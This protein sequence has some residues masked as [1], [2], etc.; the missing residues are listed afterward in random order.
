MPST[1][2]DPSLTN[3]ANIVSNGSSPSSDVWQYPDTPAQSILNFQ[4]VPSQPVP[5]G[6]STGTGLIS[7]DLL[8]PDR[9]KNFSP[10]VFDLSPDSALIHFMQALLGDSGVGQL[11]KRQVITRLQEGITGSQ[12]YDLD[13][14]YG[15]LFNTVRG[16]TSSLPLNP[17]TGVPVNPY[18]D[19]ASPDGWD[20]IDALDAK[21]RE[22]IIQLAR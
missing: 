10:D 8:L 15:A 13:A 16:L 20:Q 4:T 19:L 21:F 3:S 5:A 6:T 9:L 14:F 7:P 12:F 17:A 2:S 11:R 18:T 1:S 22:R